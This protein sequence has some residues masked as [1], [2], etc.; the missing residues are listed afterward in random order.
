MTPVCSRV[1]T[2]V[3]PHLEVFITVFCKSLFY[4][5]GKRGEGDEMKDNVI[6]KNSFQGTI[7]IN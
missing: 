5:Q 3:H 2:R 4:T 1:Y 7:L 6:L